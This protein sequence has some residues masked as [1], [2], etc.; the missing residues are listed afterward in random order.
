M[1]LIILTEAFLSLTE[2]ASDDQWDL[3]LIKLSI[4]DID[5][6]YSDI[7]YLKIIYLK[8]YAKVLFYFHPKQVE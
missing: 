4:Q 7:E 6:E 5:I 3:M 8:K 1:S 2:D